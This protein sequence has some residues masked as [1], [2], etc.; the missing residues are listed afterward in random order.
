M[1]SVTGDDEH[2]QAGLMPPQT[3][4]ALHWDSSP[5]SRTR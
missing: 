2:Q 1:V 3:Q 4:L 5:T